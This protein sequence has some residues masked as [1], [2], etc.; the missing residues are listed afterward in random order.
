MVLDEKCKETRRLVG[1]EILIIEEKCTKFC[2]GEEGS[3]NGASN[4]VIM[5]EFIS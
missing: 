2:L 3:Q 1:R 4:T 5:E